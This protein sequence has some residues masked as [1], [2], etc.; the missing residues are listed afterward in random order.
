MDGFSS[1]EGNEQILDAQNGN[2][3]NIGVN[4]FPKDAR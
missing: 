4:Q 3:P 2:F 1:E